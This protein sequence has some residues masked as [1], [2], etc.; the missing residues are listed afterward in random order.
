MSSVAVMLYLQVYLCHVCHYLEKQGL[1]NVLYQLQLHM[2]DHVRA[3]MTCIRFYQKG[4]RKYSDLAANLEHLHAAQG[5]LENELLTAQW[6]H[7]TRS[8]PGRQFLV[9]L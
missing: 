3:A 1:F 2:H 4:A 5:H 7:S 9:T 6:G 8:S